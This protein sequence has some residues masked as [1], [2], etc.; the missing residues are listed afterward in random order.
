MPLL[1]RIF[2]LFRPEPSPAD[3]LADNRARAVDRARAAATKPATYKLGA[4]GRSPTAPTPHTI[5]DGVLGSDC[6]GF[7]SW[8][9][10][11]DRYQPKTFSLYDGWINT[12]SLMAD[13]RGKREWY[14][15]IARPVPGDVVVYPSTYK[16]GV[17][18]RIG[19]IGLVSFVPDGMP[20]DVYALP[21]AERR[22]WLQR[23]LVIDCAGAAARR[24]YA[25]KE[26][27]AAPT[28]DKPDAM[29]ARCRRASLP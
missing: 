28:W 8:C 17:R 1:D 4:G 19:H 13:A 11:H 23:V 12:D 2:A 29:F 26:A 27:P 7:T 24:P 10:G 14:E 25:I 20:A 21:A 3:P 6:V 5:R 16:D 22:S 9:L 15:P 18:Q